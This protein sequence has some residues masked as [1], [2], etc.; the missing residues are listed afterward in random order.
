MLHTRTLL[1]YTKMIYQNQQ[2]SGD[3]SK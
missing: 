3:A 1:I 2:I